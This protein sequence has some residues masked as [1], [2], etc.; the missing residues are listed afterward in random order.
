VINFKGIIAGI[1]CFLLVQSLFAVTVQLTGSFPFAV[2]VVAFF[3][4]FSMYKR[5]N[6]RHLPTQPESKS[7]TPGRKS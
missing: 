5:S 6:Q 1:I 7:H 3:V 4:G 2:G